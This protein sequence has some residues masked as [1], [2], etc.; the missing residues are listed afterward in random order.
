MLKRILR[1]NGRDYIGTY[2][3]AISCM[4]LIAASTAFLAWIMEDVVNEAFFNRNE[5]AIW[6]VSAGILASFLVRG[7]ASYLII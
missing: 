6:L 4:L 5:R 2:A 1:E 3:I 7:A